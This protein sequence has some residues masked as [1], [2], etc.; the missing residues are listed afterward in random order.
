MDWKGVRHA[1]I[2]TAVPG[3]V[4][5]PT[6]DARRDGP[7]PEE[8]SREFEP[9]GEMIR[10]WVKQADLDNG[11]RR[12][13]LISEEKKEFADL[14]HMDGLGWHGLR[15]KFADEH[16]DV[17]AKDLADLGGWETTR[18]ISEV[19]QGADLGAMRRAQE[20]R[21]T[22]RAERRAGE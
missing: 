17:P 10:N 7:P 2:E 21:Q 20:N 11:R 6:G 1:E 12:D 3:G 22:L 9:C 8:L 14:E 13:G 4:S 18:T 16:R 5:P 15:R 19:Y